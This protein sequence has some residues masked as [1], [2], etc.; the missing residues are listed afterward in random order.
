MKRIITLLIVFVLIIMFVPNFVGATGECLFIE[1]GTEPSNVT[2][3][4]G[5]YGPNSFDVRD[6]NIYVL[7]TW[8]YTIKQY[9]LD[10]TFY[11][12]YSYPEHLYAMD[13]EICDDEVFIMC[14]DCKIYSAELGSETLV[15]QEEASYSPIDVV[16]LASESSTV[17]ARVVDGVD[18]VV[19]A[20]VPSGENT[21][22]IT[23]QNL[24]ATSSVIGG[25]TI[26]VT[27]NGTSYNVGLK[28]VPV[29]TFILKS[30]ENTTYMVEKE[31]LLGLGYIEVR[32]GKYVNGIKVATAILAQTSTYT[33]YVPYKYYCVSDEGIVYQM[34]P[35]VDGIEI[36]KVNWQSGAQTM[37]SDAMVQRNTEI[38]NENE[39]DVASA[40]S[41]GS[42]N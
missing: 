16:C 14:D 30:N 17:Y 37:I 23:T 31:A 33:S 21:S 27:K 42:V 28:G 10:G 7:D 32:I 11:K 38:C 35:T 20:G 19:S 4:Y 39:L 36:G 26:T 25:S 5:M 34:I 9:A 29:G 8:S 22:Q 40:R 3:K 41:I 1:Y 6:N 2:V 24:S 12:S 13:M 18:M 15:W